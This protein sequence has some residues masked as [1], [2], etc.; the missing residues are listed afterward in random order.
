[1]RF[2]EL[3]DN[4]EES[5]TIKEKARNIYWNLC[6]NISYDERFAYSKNRELLYSIYNREVDI[7]E[8]EDTRLI[9][10]TS[11][12]VYLQLLERMGIRAKLIYK[13]SSVE[14]PIEVDDVALIFF[15]EDG[16]Y[17]TNIV[18]DIQNC[19]YGLKTKYF[20]ITKNLY[21][22][23]QDVKEI[24]EEELKQIDLKTNCIK[25][26]Y[27]NMVFKLLGEEV[28]NTNNFKNFLKSQ[29]IDV[30][31]L[32]KE[33]ILQNKIEYMTKL[34]KFRDKSAGPDEM[35]KFYQKLF[36]ASV[37]DKFESKKFNTFE[38]V[39]EMETEVDVISCIE[40]NLSEGPI[41]YVYSEEEQTYFQ[42]SPEELKEK[43]RGYRERKGKELQIDKEKNAEIT[44]G[45]EESLTH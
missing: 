2:I 26:D 16:E 25:L 36:C 10:H 5:W 8:D 30:D 1:M 28:K 42:L 22:E 17:Y 4:I 6:K 23:A 35:K 41:Y 9:C 11:N 12:K 29:G 14:R 44:V 13:K 33:Q 43:T 27:Y 37:L 45:E 39:K 24:P 19:K 32:T 38:F 7:E 40:I 31:H 15:D 18:G 34:I 3:L 21:E 20:G